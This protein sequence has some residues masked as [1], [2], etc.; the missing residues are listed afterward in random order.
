MALMTGGG[1]SEYAPL[2]AVL[3]YR[4]GRDIGNHHNPASILHLA[5]IDHPALMREFDAVIAVYERLGIRVIMIDDTPLSGDRDYHW[6][7]MYCRDLFFMTPQGAIIARMANDVRREE[8]QYA[9]RA[10]AGLDIPIL[11]AVSAPGCF[12]G[13]D[14]L[15]LRDDTL[16][17]GVGNRTNRDGFAQ[18]A[19]ALEP[20]GISCIAVPSHQTR[21]QH[22]LGS[23]QIV[24]RDL[25]LVRTGIADPQVVAV[26][27]QFG[28]TPVAVPEHPEVTG[29]QAMNIVTVA[30]GSIIMTADCPVT[31][32]LYRSAGLSIVA[33]PDITQLMN[34]AGGLA[35]ATGIVVRG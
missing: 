31:R 5:P 14:A 26:L 19:G 8:P 1:S 16:L 35:C 12:E 17:V 27:E 3:L 6:N 2:S 29:R 32:E 24:D 21:T 7:M 23:M 4:P 34:G 25:A 28:F 10:L 30:P 9:A 20:R 33:E 15:W 11:H 13:A 18:I 22:L